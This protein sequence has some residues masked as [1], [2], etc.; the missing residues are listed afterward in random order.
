LSEM[1]DYSDSD[2]SYKLVPQGGASKIN[3]GGTD[4]SPEIT[5]DDGVLEGGVIRT[6]KTG[7]R[8]VMQRRILGP[9]NGTMVVV[10]NV[11][12]VSGIDLVAE[13]V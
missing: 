5:K 1:I 9:L 6:A 4:N 13:D 10:A 3:L 7:K 2:T 8:A 12:T 11:I